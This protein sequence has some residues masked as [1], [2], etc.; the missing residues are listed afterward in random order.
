MSD[1]KIIDIVNP[2]VLAHYDLLEEIG[3]IDE[4][5]RLHVRLR[6]SSEVIREAASLFSE[7]SVDSLM[8][9]LVSSLVDKFI[10]SHLILVLKDRN[11]KASPSIVC[12]EN[13]KQ[14][15]SPLKINN[16]EPF[17]NFFSAR[18]K[19]INF[20]K[21][22]SELGSTDIADSLGPLA[23]E[24]IFPLMGIDGIFGFLVFG[25]KIVDQD[26]SPEEVKYIEDLVTFASISLQN[27]INYADAI[28]DFK[29]GLYNHSFFTRRMGE[30]LANAKRYEKEIT[31]LLIDIDHFKRLN[32][33]YGHLA[34]DEVLV[35]IA[36][37]IR[38]AIRA[39]D[40]VSR[41]GGEEFAVLLVQTVEVASLVTA[42]R[43]RK[44]VEETSVE[45]LGNRLNVTVSVGV[46]NIGKK[47]DA[48]VE[49]I[50][51]QAD[52]ALYKAKDEG[53]NRVCVYDDRLE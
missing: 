12:F 31:L 33:T 18:P 28:T 2:E 26:Y 20:S 41:F 8:D 23:P 40:I 25:R 17:Y 4:L 16:F 53:R 48:T 49:T 51:H 5:D 22:R 27:I 52:Q 3:I 1:G 44:T 42:E 32:D 30:E 14:V 35:C 19:S 46:R 24:Y 9:H 11:H 6:Q 39:G 38:H 47:D 21:F 10:P 15:A 29:T 7:P 36:D 43:I 37:A 50:I 45:Y 13:L 34:G